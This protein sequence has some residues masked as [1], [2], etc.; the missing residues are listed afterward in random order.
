[1]LFYLVAIGA[2]VLLTGDFASQKSYQRLQ[3]AAA[4]A[5]FLFNS[6]QGIFV[7]L[8]F[9]VLTGFSVGFS[10]YSL[11]MAAAFTSL[12][13]TY[14]LIGFKIMEYGSMSVYTVFLMAGGMTIPYVWGLLFLDEVF[15]WFRMAGLV[16]ILAAVIITGGKMKFGGYKPLLLCILVFVL[17]GFVSVISKLHAIETVYPTVSSMQFVFWTAAA[18]FI[19]CGAALMLL[20]LRQKKAGEK[21]L[22]VKPKA[23]FWIGMSALVGNVSYLMQLVCA[24]HL[25]ASVLYP[26]VTGGSVIMT[27]LSAW[28]FFKEKP[29]KRTWFGI[30]VC[31][32][33]TCMFLW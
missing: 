12:C 25:P 27:A 26:I 9:L 10:G 5:G 17:N 22:S 19:L 3:G 21:T 31:F 20:V 15:S 28:L 6:V 23:V 24:E 18:K 30:A 4:K 7:M 32:A 33:G 16:L 2:T 14:S 8:L 11:L 1:M 29:D 13:F